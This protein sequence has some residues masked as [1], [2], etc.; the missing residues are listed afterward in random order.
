MADTERKFPGWRGTTILSVR[1]NGKVVL[2]GDGQVSIGDTVVKA[3]A[4]KVRPIAGGKVITGFGKTSCGNCF[5]NTN[6][7]DRPTYRPHTANDINWCL[8]TSSQVYHCTVTL[9]LG[10]AT[11]K[12]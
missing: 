1:K 9:V 4:R 10:V 7:S 6:V 5:C 3:T 12:A 11:K 2:A 8:G